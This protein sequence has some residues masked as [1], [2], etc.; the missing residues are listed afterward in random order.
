MPTCATSV[1]DD[2]HSPRHFNKSDWLVLVGGVSAL[3]VA[4]LRLVAA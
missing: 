4:E 1:P 3:T 2:D